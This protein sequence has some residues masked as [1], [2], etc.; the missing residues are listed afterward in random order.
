VSRYSGKVLDVASVSTA[1]GGV[2]Y[3]WD[4]A[5]GSN[6]QFKAVSTGNGYYKLEARHSG[7]VLDVADCTKSG[8]G[9][10][11]RLQQWTWASGNDCQQ[12]RLEAL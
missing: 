5:N 1:D 11:A 7:K 4:W 10:G 3:Q 2:V 12:F 6:Q 8:V 9:D